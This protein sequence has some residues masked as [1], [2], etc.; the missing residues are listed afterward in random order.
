M[1][2]RAFQIRT[3]YSVVV[4]LDDA[5][6]V[7]V[8]RL[9]APAFSTIPANQSVPEDIGLAAVYLCS[10]SSKLVTVVI[11]PID[12]GASIGFQLTENG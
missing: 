2:P 10:P 9:G 1:M 6:P 4:L 3:S 8:S 12:G 7:P 5:K 11:L